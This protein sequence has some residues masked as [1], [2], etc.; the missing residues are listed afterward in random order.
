[1]TIS[2]EEARVDLETDLTTLSNLSPEQ[3]EEAVDHYI[4]LLSAVSQ[5]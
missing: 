1:M 4:N 5:P 3:A 2:R